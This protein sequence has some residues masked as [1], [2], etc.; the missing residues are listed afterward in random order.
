MLDNYVAANADIHKAIDSQNTKI[1]DAITTHTT[2][3]A[4]I[5]R[6]SDDLKNALTKLIGDAKGDI[7][8]L[9]VEVT[10]L[11]NESASKE[12]LQGINTVMMGRCA[13]ME[14]TVEAE[15]TALK[16][17]MKKTEAELR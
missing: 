17:T 2:D 12:S 1:A 7:T 9:Q 11:K 16:L 8:S 5:K 10:A 6:E 3:M 15:V 13:G 4:T 14:K